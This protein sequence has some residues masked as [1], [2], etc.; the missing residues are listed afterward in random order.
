VP[1]LEKRLNSRELQD[2]DNIEMLNYGD[3]TQIPNAKKRSSNR[4]KAIKI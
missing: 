1:K 2:D 4:I 3:N